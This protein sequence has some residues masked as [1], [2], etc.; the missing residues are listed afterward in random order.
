VP[1]LK[2]DIQALERLFEKEVPAQT[3]IQASRIYTI[4]YGFADASGSGFGS[5]VLGENGIRYRIGTWDSDTQD[6]SSN[7][8]EFMNVVE[9]LLDEAREGHL[10]NALIFLCTDNSTVEAALAKGNS[11]SPKLFELVLKI[12]LLEM[13]EGA[14]IIVSHVSERMKAQGTDGVSR[15]QLKEG[16]SVGKEMLSFIPFHLSAV[17][18]SS[19]VEPWIHS[20]LGAEPELLQPEGSKEVMESWGGGLIK[21]AFGGMR[22]NRE[23]SYGHPLPQ[24]QMWPLKSFARLG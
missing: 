13:Q 11:S 23:N 15:G 2:G 10:R 3:L 6:S 14:K 8:R 18:R 4:L 21:R 1:R 20:W 5:T 7:F 22:S 24:Q 19:K 17:Q 9:A 12:R 16:V